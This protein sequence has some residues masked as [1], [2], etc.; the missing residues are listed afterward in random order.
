MLAP[1]AADRGRLAARG[2]PA[3]VRRVVHRGVLPAAARRRRSDGGRGPLLCHSALPFA[4]THVEIL[5]ATLQ[6]ELEMNRD[7]G[8]TLG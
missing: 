6:L 7:D 8:D 1:A 5:F 3:V 4:G 2:G